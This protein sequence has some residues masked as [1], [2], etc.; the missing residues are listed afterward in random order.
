MMFKPTFTNGRSRHGGPNTVSSQI[1]PT[2]LSQIQQTNSSA[3][4]IVASLN[5]AENSHSWRQKNAL[6]WK[7]CPRCRAIFL[8]YRKDNRQYCSRQCNGVLRGQEWAKHANKGRAAWT[9][10]SDASYRAK[11]SGPNNP[12]WRGGVTI[13]RTHGNYSGVRYVRCPQEYASMARKDGYV[14]EHRL[15]VAQAL[16]RCLLRSEVVHHIDHAPTNNLLSNLVLFASNADHKKHE[17]G[18]AIRPLWQ[19]SSRSGTPD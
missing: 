2:E 15:L 11:M 3:A 13:F 17:H 7:E 19:P 14:M 12:A 10:E 8:G 18:Q 5:A 1:P 16:G 6:L 4:T 9:P